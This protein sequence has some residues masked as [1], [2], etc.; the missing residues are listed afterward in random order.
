M[1]MIVKK[2]EFIFYFNDDLAN[3][4]SRDDFRFRIIWCLKVFVIMDATNPNLSDLLEQYLD[5]DLG[6]FLNFQTL[7]QIW[8]H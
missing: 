6:L 3:I 8:G 2:I 1:Y 4:Q 7:W 5:L